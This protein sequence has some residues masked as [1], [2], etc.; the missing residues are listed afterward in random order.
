MAAGVKKLPQPKNRW[1]QKE[2]RALNPFLESV[3]EAE[4]EPTLDTLFEDLTPDFSRILK[5][6]NNN[7]RDALMRLEL[8]LLSV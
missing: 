6:S 8:E 5:D 4:Y 3:W 7:M 1:P 2:G